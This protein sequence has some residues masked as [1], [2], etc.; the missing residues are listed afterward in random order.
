MSISVVHGHLSEE[1]AKQMRNRGKNLKTKDGKPV[2]V[3]FRSGCKLFFPAG[4]ICKI[5]TASL[6]SHLGTYVP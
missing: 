3:A 6:K 4:F 1:A 2:S 5:N